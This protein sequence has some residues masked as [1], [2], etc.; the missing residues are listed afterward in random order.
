M[1]PHGDVG[2]KGPSRGGFSVVPR[3]F[4]PRTQIGLPQLQRPCPVLFTKGYGKGIS[5]I[6][7]EGF[8]LW[9]I[10][11]HVLVRGGKL[12]FLGHIQI[13][14][15]LPQPGHDF[16]NHHFHGVVGGGFVVGHLSMKLI[17]GEYDVGH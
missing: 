4:R 9:P 12:D 13:T 3:I 11:V 7:I 16:Q 8:H 5:A 6:G 14:E 10:K 15:S 17:G 1:D 2:G